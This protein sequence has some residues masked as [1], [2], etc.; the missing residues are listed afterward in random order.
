MTPKKVTEA[1]AS[2]ATQDPGALATPDGRRWLTW[3]RTYDVFFSALLDIDY[4]LPCLI[5]TTS[6]K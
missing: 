3:L 6:K 5:S 2:I 4:R 1:L